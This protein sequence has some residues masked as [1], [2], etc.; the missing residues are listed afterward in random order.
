M[1]STHDVGVLHQAAIEVTYFGKARDGSLAPIRSILDIA[2]GT[3]L[4][5]FDLVCLTDI[6]IRL[7]AHTQTRVGTPN[8]PLGGPPGSL[9][10]GR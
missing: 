9:G 5:T 8:A 10:P 2:S 7:Q 3:D 6:H 4:W 1:R